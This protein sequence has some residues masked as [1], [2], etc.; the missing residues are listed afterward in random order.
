MGSFPGTLG[1]EEK[2]FQ[3]REIAK[4]ARL[5]FE[6]VIRRFPRSLL[7]WGLFDLDSVG[8]DEQVGG[9]G[10]IDK[11][12]LDGRTSEGAGGTDYEAE[13]GRFEL[14]AGRPAGRY[15]RHR[16]VTILVADDPGILWGHRCRT[17]CSRHE[18]LASFAK[19]EPN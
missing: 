9:S 17:S 6:R 1:G 13:A 5:P 4:T 19:F 7:S 16:F 14:L 15:L 3:S 18:V 10:K 12:G 8:R 2:R 11:L